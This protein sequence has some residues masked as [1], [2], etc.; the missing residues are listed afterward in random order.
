[1]NPEKLKQLSNSGSKELWLEALRSIQNDAADIRKGTYSTEA[2][3]AVVNI[4]DE[5]LKKLNVA[6]GEPDNSV[7]DWR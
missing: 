6:S 7:E 4:I 5:F 1:M 3:V 2:R